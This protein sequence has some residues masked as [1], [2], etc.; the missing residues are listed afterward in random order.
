MIAF[1]GFRNNLTCT[2]GN[3]I[4]QYREGM[5]FEEKECNIAKN[6]FHCCENPLDVLSYY[7]N[8]ESDIYYMVEAAGDITEDGAN[9][10]TCTR[11]RLLKK[12]TIVEL[13][14]Y[15]AKYMYEHPERKWNPMVQH[16]KGKAKGINAFVI[17]RGKKPKAA[18][19]MGAYLLILQE[20]RKG[21]GIKR[22]TIMQVGQNGIRAG[23]Y[24]DSEEKEIKQSGQ[25]KTA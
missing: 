23:R 10:L 2:M 9:K 17:V 18:G 16:E 1:K 8:T 4:F 6:G 20:Y 12:L 11:I 21:P 15:A 25:E 19:E 13:L 24:Y 3:G 7:G 22:I 14:A 5:W